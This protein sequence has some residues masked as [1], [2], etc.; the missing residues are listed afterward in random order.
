MSF[1]IVEQA[2]PR[3]N[4]SELAVPGSNPSLFEKDNNLFIDTSNNI[5]SIQL[6]LQEKEDRWLQLMELD[7]NWLIIMIE[8]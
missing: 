2:Q 8:S 1:Y 4:R 6:K 7:E 5:G 3:L